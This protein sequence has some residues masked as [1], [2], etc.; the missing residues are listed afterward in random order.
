MS[1]PVADD[2]LEA[3]LR[4]FQPVGPPPALRA[5]VV[6]PTPARRSWPWA[7]AAAAA[8]IA[9][10]A[11][12]ALSART[13]AGARMPSAH[14]PWLPVAT[15]LANQVDDSNAADSLRSVLVATASSHTAAAYADLPMLERMNHASR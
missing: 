15:A 2:D 11:S 13:L 14:E 12:H 9:A 10:V 3:R 7:V 5:H 4:R 8:L 1:T 6:A